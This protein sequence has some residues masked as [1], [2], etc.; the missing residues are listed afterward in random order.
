M[1]DLLDLAIEAH[2]GLSRWREVEGI[3][4]H[5]TVGGPLWAMKGH[6]AGLKDVAVRVSAHRPEVA[7]KPFGDQA[8]TGHFRPDA[9]WLETPAD[10]IAYALSDPHASF[11]GHELTTPWTE[12][13]ALYF[14]SYAVWNYMALPFLLV[15]PGFETEELSGHSGF[16]NT[17]R[18]LRVRFPAHVPAHSREQILY[19]SEDGLLR[20]LDY[21]V[22]IA[23][24]APAAHY[25]FDHAE[26]GGLVIP[27]LRRA[28]SRSAISPGSDWWGPTGVL[29][30]ISDVGVH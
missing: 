3:D 1:K 22:D 14:I 27:T 17:W 30:L 19:F 13:Q 20:R 12:L 29:L 23:Q 16:G 6:A 18:R 11:D 15:E 7:I 9:V 2:G 24:Q 5:M 26:V 10:G 8:A 21:S 4:F 25:C 28:V